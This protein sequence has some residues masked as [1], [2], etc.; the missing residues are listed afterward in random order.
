MRII[1]ALLG[2]NIA[3]IAENGGLEMFFAYKTLIYLRVYFVQWICGNVR[4]GT[5]K[6]AEFLE[7]T[8][9]HA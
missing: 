6:F 1:I 7:I 3:I 2:S 5:F 4:R 9:T 8:K